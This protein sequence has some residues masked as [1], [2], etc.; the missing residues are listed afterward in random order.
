M[1]LFSGDDPGGENRHGGGAARVARDG[2]FESAPE[3]GVLRDA[4]EAR[5]RVHECH[6]EAAAPGMDTCPGRSWKG[7]RACDEALERRDPEHGGSV[8]HRNSLDSAMTVNGAPIARFRSGTRCSARGLNA[9]WREPISPNGMGRRSEKPATARLTPSSPHGA[10]RSGFSNAG[11]WTFTR[12]SQTIWFPAGEASIRG[13]R[14]CRRRPR[15]TALPRLVC[16]F[17]DR[18][19]NDNPV[20]SSS[21][22]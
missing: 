12:A 14:Q 13:R 16:A 3:T 15:R 11:R 6:G 21:F 20:A 22:E 9:A 18:G 10:R 19:M 8:V 1:P 7:K 4:G 2:D 5:C 17:G